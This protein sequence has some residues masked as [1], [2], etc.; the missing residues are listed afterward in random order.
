M[1]RLP[2]PKWRKVPFLRSSCPCRESSRFGVVIATVG[3]GLIFVQ[4]DTLN[5]VIAPTRFLYMSRV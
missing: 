1:T 4:R 2:S 3:S 5:E